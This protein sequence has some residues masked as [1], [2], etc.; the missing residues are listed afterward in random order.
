MPGETVMGTDF[1]MNPG[2]KG[3][4]QAVAAARLG[5]KVTLV[6]RVGNDLFG[7]QALK[8]FQRENIDIRFI[9]TDNEHPSGVALIG[10]DAQGE[11][12][13][14]VAAGS[15][16]YLDEQMVEEALES[17]HEPAII[18]TQLEIPLDT[19][20]LAIKKGVAKGWK[21][22]VNPAP[23][24][25]INKAAFRDLYLLTPNE[26][27]AE[28]LTGVRVTNIDSAEQAAQT[29]RQLGVSNVV[30]TLG[31]RGAFLHTQSLGKVIAAPTV[32]PIDTTAAGDCFNG[33][34][35]VALSQGMELE[36]AVGFAC[37]AASVSVT[38]MGA[39]SSMPSRKELNEIFP[40]STL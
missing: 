30:I 38:R 36:E 6:A 14:M 31:S 32:T 10:V 40:Q 18:L 26:Y 4:N 22:I 3:A 20:E 21:V 11:N 2:G 15:N 1:F 27:E 17:I 24:R 35:A 19:V 8:Q 28:I 13:I 23:A 34:I 25:L 7:R 12:S 39:Q 9:G 29:L 5:G 16:G 33:A 37:R